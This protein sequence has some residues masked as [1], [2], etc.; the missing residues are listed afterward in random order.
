MHL[1]LSLDIFNPII[2]R[3][4]G[5]KFIG[6]LKEMEIVL[7]GLNRSKSVVFQDGPGF[8]YETNYNGYILPIIDIAFSGEVGIE[9][10]NYYKERCVKNSSHSLQTAVD[11][12]FNGNVEA[13]NFL[14]R[15]YVEKN[16]FYKYLIYINDQ[17]DY[18]NGFHNLT[19]CELLSIVLR[20][21]ENDSFNKLFRGYARL[22]STSALFGPKSTDTIDLYKTN[23]IQKFV[24]QFSKDRPTLSIPL[25]SIV[26]YVAF[27]D[28]INIET[29]DGDVLWFGNRSNKIS[30]APLPNSFNL[31][32]YIAES[33]LK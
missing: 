23:L 21:T 33:D 18:R 29:K 8:F 6:K 11:F 9:S 12:C 15:R 26:R 13:Q 5:Q 10:H 7:K 31:R 25:A 28:G 22:N 19:L 4:S 20:N 14:L 16:Y 24:N 1:K 3:F 2:E 17:Y 32:K 30:F 27:Y